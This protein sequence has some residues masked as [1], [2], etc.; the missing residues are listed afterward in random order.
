MSAMFTELK[1]KF[2]EVEDARFSIGAPSYAYG[3]AN[4]VNACCFSS[5]AVV[6]KL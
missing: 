6:P 2:L 5:V 4:A 1:L 3:N